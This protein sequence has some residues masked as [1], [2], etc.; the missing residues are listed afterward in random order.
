[1]NENEKKKTAM[2]TKILTYQ[3]TQF[4]QNL[5]AVLINSQKDISEIPLLN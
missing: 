3:H 1:M 5:N 4:M 2:A